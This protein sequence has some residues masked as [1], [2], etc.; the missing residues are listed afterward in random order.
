MLFRFILILLLALC[1]PAFAQAQPDA[2]QPMSTQ[3]HGTHVTVVA[4]DG[5][6]IDDMCRGAVAALEFFRFHGLTKTVPTQLEVVD[7][8]PYGGRS[9]AVG[10][11]SRVERRAYA[12]S[13]KSFLERKVWLGLPVTRGLYV[14][15][16]TH[17]VAHA[18][19]ACN[20]SDFPLSVQATEYIAFTAMLFSM[21]SELRSQVLALYPDAD[22]ASDW[23]VTDVAY[24][25]DPIR[26]GV[27]SYRHFLREGDKAALLGAIMAG[28]LFGPRQ[29]Y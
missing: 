2:G 15:I 25:L 3:C 27:S 29:M 20:A 10:C 16:A 24:A 13:F 18:L 23:D 21:K 26:F 11:F 9:A 5:P 8:L 22:F 4:K 6:D 7:Q 19:T 14:S 12:L 17:E 28:T 1:K